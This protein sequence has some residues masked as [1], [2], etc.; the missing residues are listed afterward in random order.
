[1]NIN[2][3]LARY[4]YDMEKCVGCKGCVWVDHI[5]MPGVRFGI[6]CASNIYDP[7]DA[8][9]YVGRCKIGL[10]VLD[11]SL[12]YSDKLLDVIYKC[13]LCGACDAGCKRNLDLEP[14]SVLE[15]LRAK[16]VSD[17]KGPLPAHKKVARNI[18]ETGNR[19]GAKQKDRLK[20]L[21]QKKVSKGADLVYF[22][23]C[24]ACYLDKGIANA[25]VEIL[26]RSGQA[27]TTL[28]DQDQCCAQPLIAAGMITAGKKIAEANIR[29]LKQTGA[30]TI[31]TS[32]AECYKTWK[33][34][35]PKLLS[36][37][38]QDMD[39]TVLHLS[40]L[41]NDLLEKDKIRFTK[42]VDMKVAWHDPCNLGRLSEP[43]THWTGN[44]GKYGLLDQPKE[45]RRGT[46][47][48]Y[49]APRNI[50]KQIPGLELVEMLR[51]RENTLCCGAGGGVREAFSDYARHVGEDRLEEAQSVS[52][53]AMVS[54]C[55]YCKENF[56]KAGE[57]SNKDIAAFDLSEIILMS[58]K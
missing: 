41:V 9:A 12:G 37:S 8:Y 22:P 49:Q 35:Y 16:C 2:Y 1:M 10:S 11:E 33:V 51:T 54:G 13:N 50:L 43:W 28:G 7:F 15:S 48:V 38:T 25:T 24:A 14:L 20:W 26:N 3:D 53:E 56:K 5:Y 55:P 34:D 52:V 6:K 21:P 29:A 47:G 58:L 30:K 23:G 40:E 46:H 45:Y 44:R 4:K 36:K 42:K 19:F 17:R 31:L 32:C 18:K 57:S 39:Y 27:F